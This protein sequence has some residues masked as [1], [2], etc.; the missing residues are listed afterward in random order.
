MPYKIPQKLLDK[1]PNLTKKEIKI[2]AGMILTNRA[3]KLRRAYIVDF[4][5]TYIGRFRTHGLKKVRRYN[6]NK[7]K[8]KKRKRV[9][10]IE[11]QFKK[12]NLLW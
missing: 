8:D 9:K 4:Y 12:E 7:L 1:H 3:D 11:K 5:V 10:Q 6:K 2:I